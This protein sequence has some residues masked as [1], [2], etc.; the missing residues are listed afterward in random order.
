MLLKTLENQVR[1]SNVLGG[2]RCWGLPEYGTL[3]EQW[4][5]TQ[6]SPRRRLG[7]E[8]GPGELQTGLTGN[9][10]KGQSTQDLLNGNGVVFIARQEGGTTKT[11]DVF[12]C[13]VAST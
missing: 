12:K 7:E 9:T 11:R 5:H 13:G 2:G 3:S 1:G 4:L 10:L 8:L 6:P